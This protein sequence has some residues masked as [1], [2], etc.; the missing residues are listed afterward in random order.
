MPEGSAAFGH[1]VGSRRL[2]AKSEGF[3]SELWVSSYGGRRREAEIQKAQTAQGNSGR[4]APPRLTFDIGLKIMPQKIESPNA[5]E[6]RWLDD[7]HKSLCQFAG[8]TAGHRFSPEEL[9]IAYRDWM[10]GKKEDED[11]NS[12]IN[13][14][15]SAFGQLFVDRLKMAWSVVTDEHG[16][17]MAVCGQPG[18][19][20]IFP[21]NFVAKRFVANEVGFFASAFAAMSRDVERLRIEAKPRPWWKPW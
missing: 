3:L 8:K 11:P 7:C 15:G 4:F 17:E 14:F 1:R 20:L 12:M 13:A 6:V 2:R 16:T 19:V 21:P 18:N 5:A 9:D 10:S